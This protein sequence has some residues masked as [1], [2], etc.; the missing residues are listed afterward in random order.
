MH[1]YNESEL[2]S[3]LDRHQVIITD[4]SYFSTITQQVDKSSCK[5]IREFC[6][7]GLDLEKMLASNKIRLGDW[8]T[9]PHHVQRVIFEIWSHYSRP[10]NEAERLSI[11]EELEEIKKGG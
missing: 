8:I 11:E 3:F 2:L 9:M 1:N 10:L 4:S 7:K 6:R 5:S